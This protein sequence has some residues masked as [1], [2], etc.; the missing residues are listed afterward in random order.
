MA[1]HTDLMGIAEDIKSGT[2]N[3]LA[4]DLARGWHE[5][6]VEGGQA[7]ADAAFDLIGNFS[8]MTLPEQIV[9]DY[10]P[11]SEVFGGVWKDIVD[12]AEKHN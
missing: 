9:S 8:Q 5:G 4:D 11:G 7:A 12:S 3:I 10:S 6:F 2:P 1:D